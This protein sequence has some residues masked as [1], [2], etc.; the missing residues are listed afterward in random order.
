MIRSSHAHPAAPLARHQRGVALVVAL[1]L[2]LVITIVGLAAV[3]STTMQQKMTSNFQDRQIAF[4]A[5]EAALREGEVA[6][7]AAVANS[8]FYNCAYDSGNNCLTNPF[9]DPNVSQGWV[10]S[11]PKSDF[12]A[13]SLAADQPEYVI[14]YLGKGYVD[15]PVKVLS[16]GSQSNC[17]GEYPLPSSCPDF[18]RITARSGPANAGDRATVTLQSIYRK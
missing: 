12:D 4:Q 2:L 10:V 9:V 8:A 6:V 7:Q 16:G 11:V 13:G 15:S 18:F 3:R 5:A 14:Q 1:L 17:D